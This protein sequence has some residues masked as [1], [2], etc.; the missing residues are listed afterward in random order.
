M[1]QL[2][3]Q[4]GC[5]LLAFFLIA[6]SV[7]TWSVTAKAEL[8]EDRWLQVQVV[9][10]NTDTGING[11]SEWMT[12]YGNDKTEVQIC[13]QYGEELSGT[14]IF[15]Y[16][17]LSTQMSDELE[18]E[19]YTISIEDAGIKQADGTFM[20]LDAL[21]GVYTESGTAIVCAD[22]TKQTTVSDITG[23]FFCATVLVI[24]SEKEETKLTDIVEPDGTLPADWY[25]SVDDNTIILEDFVFDGTFSVVGNSRY[26]VINLVLK[27]D[28][29]IDKLVISCPVNIRRY[30][31]GSLTV[32]EYILND[33][34]SITYDS[35]Y[36]RT[37]LTQSGTSAVFEFDGSVTDMTQS[38]LEEKNNTYNY[39]WRHKNADWYSRAM[40]EMEKNRTAKLNLQ[41]TD[42]NGYPIQNGNISL[43]Q[44]DYDYAFGFGTEAA[45]YL[46]PDTGEMPAYVLEPRTFGINTA[47]FYTSFL[48]QYFD[49]SNPD[50]YDFS[51]TDY[52]NVAF[53]KDA[54]LSAREAG[55]EVSGQ[56]LLYPSFNKLN[57]NPLSSETYDTVAAYVLSEEYTPRGFKELINRHIS[58]EITEYAGIVFDWA[59]VNEAF[60]STDFFKLIYGTDGSGITREQIAA[61]T[62]NAG[63]NEAKLNALVAY[64]NTVELTPAEEAAK[65]IAEFAETAQAAWDATVTAD[66][67][68]TSEDL[69]FYYNDAPYR[70]NNTL[71]EE[72]HYDYVLQLAAELAKPGTYRNGKVLVDRV[73]IQYPGTKGYISSPEEL[74]TTLEEF[75]TVG[76]RVWLTEFCYWV[77][78]PVSMY[79][80]NTKWYGE[81]TPGYRTTGIASQAEKEFLYDYTYFILTALYAHSDSAG[82]VST[83]YPHGQIGAQFYF[84]GVEKEVTPLGEACIQLIKNEWM[85][86]EKVTTDSVGRAATGP[87]HYGTYRVTVTVGDYTYTD[88]IRVEAGNTDLTIVMPYAVT[89]N[90]DN[91]D[92]NSDNNAENN[93]LNVSAAQSQDS[94]IL[95]RAEDRTGHTLWIGLLIGA[96][97][98]AVILFYV[99]KKGK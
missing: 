16:F 14:D 17:F 62:G 2:A 26:P 9:P 21:N 37:R 42:I 28:C 64:L 87:L 8:L 46:D 10:Y 18:N 12:V 86:S 53:V 77:N 30:A 33:G 40:A 5:M 1:R 55:I 90:S 70:G 79:G 97:L 69:S 94:S 88:S 35:V 80:D 45:T 3:K 78:N 58:E 66:C 36:N 7:G 23:G 20:P 34:G 51:K 31:Y 41:L 13:I 49:S 75:E 38:E 50:V 32:E 91:T 52:G 47:I 22:D 68:Y 15:N 60:Y 73:G 11:W 82:I 71:G 85:S 74:W 48:W 44:T 4:I 76:Q 43:I 25:Y 39:P 93:E 6:G 95:Q 57:D 92:S 19:T 54:V 72:G 98:A 29:R 83:G 27:G 61:V 67:G 63:T 96:V 65:L 81:A 84:N 56:T 59:I 99:R 89:D 24:F